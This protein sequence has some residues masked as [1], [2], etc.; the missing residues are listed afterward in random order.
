MSVVNFGF[1]LTEL[2]PPFG[3][4]K[5]I[6]MKIDERQANSCFINKKMNYMVKKM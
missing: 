4:R 2:D 5:N 3:L 6:M 1:F